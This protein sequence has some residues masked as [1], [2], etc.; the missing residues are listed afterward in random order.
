MWYRYDREISHQS[1]LCYCSYCAHIPTYDFRMLSYA[2]D[3]EGRNKEGKELV[4]GDMT[5]EEMER[6]VLRIFRLK[7]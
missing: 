4:F 5:C 3:L 2:A 6:I 7:M 1:T